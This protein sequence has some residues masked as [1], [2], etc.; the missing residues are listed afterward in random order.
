MAIKRTLIDFNDRSWQ[1]S[2]VKLTQASNGILSGTFPI[3]WPLTADGGFGASIATKVTGYEY[4]FTD[5]QVLTAAQLIGIIRPGFTVQ[6]TGPVDVDNAQRR[7]TILNTSQVG[8]V[9]LNV[10]QEDLPWNDSRLDVD[11]RITYIINS[12]NGFETRIKAL[13]AK[14]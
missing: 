6:T 1:T 10:V 11:D 3:F 8:L 13:E 5:G 9:Q 12:L 7:L 2:T 14:P 4:V